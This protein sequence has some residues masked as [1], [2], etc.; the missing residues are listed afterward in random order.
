MRRPAAR[1][2][3]GRVAGGQGVDALAYH[4][5]MDGGIRASNQ[6]RFVT[7]DDMVMVATIAF[8]MGIDKPDV[9]FVAHLGLPKSIE[10]YYQ[11]TGRA[12]RD[13]DPAVAHMLYGA[14]DIARQR[15][16]ID[17]SEARCERKARGARRA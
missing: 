1:P 13:G 12:G 9:R 4:A 15:G 5:G 10:A 14:D 3:D 2:S 17:M 11:E 16:F 6:E 8:G 7:A